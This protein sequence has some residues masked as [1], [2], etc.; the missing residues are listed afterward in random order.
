MSASTPPEE[1]Q[2]TGAKPK[3]ALMLPLF[4]VVALLVLL[5]VAL[6]S[7]DPARLPS[8][9]IGKPI[10]EFDLPAVPKVLSDFGPVPG[11]SSGTFRKGAVS[12]LNVWASWCAPCV[13]EHPQLIELAKRGVP[14]YAI[15]YKDTAEN[16]RRFLSRHGNPFQAIGVDQD[17]FT[18]IDF[19]VYGVP[20]T[21]VIDGSGRIVY[22]FPGPLTPETLDGKIMPAIESARHH[23][24]AP[25]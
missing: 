21:F 23:A 6:R 8:A 18:A 10:P 24:R 4:L 2:T 9:L 19:G 5:F 17:G 25:R 11:L 15:N 13:A 3:A 1:A 22:R 12:V 7:G 14:L 16:A 20:E